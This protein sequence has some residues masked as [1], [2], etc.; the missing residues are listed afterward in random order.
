MHNSTTPRS[1]VAMA[2]LEYLQ[3]TFQHKGHS[4]AAHPATGVRRPPFAATALSTATGARRRHLQLPP[5]GGGIAHWLLSTSHHTKRGGGAEKHRKASMDSTTGSVM[6]ATPQKLGTVSPPF[7]F[8][9][10]QLG[11]QVCSWLLR[12]PCQTAQSAHPDAEKSER[13]P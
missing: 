1:G 8:Q 11:V 12:G 6:G 13:S 7:T 9:G 3:A 5:L 4:R 2:Y 10:H